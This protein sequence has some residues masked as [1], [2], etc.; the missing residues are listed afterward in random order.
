MK[1][2]TNVRSLQSDVTADNF[3][4]IEFKTPGMTYT[5]WL[6]PDQ[7]EQLARELQRTMELLP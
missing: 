1:N 3:P 7:V 2:I 6:K 5:I 4:W